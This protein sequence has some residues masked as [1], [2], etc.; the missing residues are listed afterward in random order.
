MHL[1]PLGTIRNAPKA[2]VRVGF[3]DGTGRNVGFVDFR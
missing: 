1:R 3:P 2:V